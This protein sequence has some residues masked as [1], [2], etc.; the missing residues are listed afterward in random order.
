MPMLQ[1][2]QVCAV[3]GNNSLTTATF[4]HTSTSSNSSSGSSIC[5]QSESF[6]KPNKHWTALM[7][8]RALGLAEEPYIHALPQLEIAT[9]STELVIDVVNAGELVT[10]IRDVKVGGRRCSPE[11]L[12]QQRLSGM[13]ERKICDQLP[14]YV[15]PDAVV[16]LRLPAM[17]SCDK[18]ARLLHLVLIA[19]NDKSDLQLE[20]PLIM[21]ASR[22]A[23]CLSG[24]EDMALDSSLVTMWRYTLKCMSALMAILSLSFFGSLMYK[25]GSVNLR[26][27]NGVNQLIALRA[28]S[29]PGTVN[30]NFTGE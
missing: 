12:L 16:S 8:R 6:P 17:P 21:S 13:E 7:L 9:R 4:H 18:S 10:V 22:V 27:E 28:A 25:W 3:S 15:F 2:K 30:K 14:M 20:V 29:K 24:A 23:A 5:L 19:A 11:N 1:M 26:T